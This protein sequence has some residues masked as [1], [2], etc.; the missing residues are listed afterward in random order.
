MLPRVRVSFEE[1]PSKVDLYSTGASE[2]PEAISEEEDESL[3]P[4]ADDVMM[5]RINLMLL[6]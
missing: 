4:K 5:I 6:Q 1:T 2:S 3:I